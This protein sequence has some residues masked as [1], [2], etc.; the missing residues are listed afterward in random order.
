MVGKEIFGRGSGIVLWG[1]AAVFVV[2]LAGL[3]T[4]GISKATRV[5]RVSFLNGMGEWSLTRTRARLGQFVHLE[6]WQQ[7]T[8]FSYSLAIPFEAEDTAGRGL[9][10]RAAVEG[11]LRTDSRHRNLADLSCRCEQPKLHHNR[12]I[13][14]TDLLR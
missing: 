3:L 6:T 10:C 13:A 12:V 1:A 8:S 5:D 7:P 14:C 9:N 4:I 2:A 11:W